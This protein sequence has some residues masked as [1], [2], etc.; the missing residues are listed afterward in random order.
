M[1]DLVRLLLE[2][3]E[4]LWP[5]KK[6]MEWERGLLYWNGRFVRVVGPGGYWCL[7][8]FHDLKTIVM[9]PDPRT[10][11]VQDVTLKD[12]DILTFSATLVFYVKS[13]AKA[14][15]LVAKHD[16]SAVETAGAILCDTL[17]DLEGERLEPDRRRG[18]IRTCLKAI[19]AELDEYGIGVQ[20]LRFN[21]FVRADK[22]YRLLT[23]SPSP[24]PE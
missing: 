11:P 12:G 17:A 15:N 13:A 4:F 6:V 16:E 9:V 1:A 10:T 14:M 3:V 7:W 2:V 18:L 22:T 23:S 24:L 20:S 21:T 19:N 8:W 5:H